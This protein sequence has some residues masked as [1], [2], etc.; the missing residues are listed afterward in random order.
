LYRPRAF[1]LFLPPLTR[2]TPTTVRPVP[3]GPVPHSIPPHDDTLGDFFARPPSGDGPFVSRERSAFVKGLR[4]AARLF[5]RLEA[6]GPLCPEGEALRRHLGALAGEIG[7]PWEGALPAV[8]EPCG[9]GHRIARRG[10]VG[11]AFI[12]AADD[13]IRKNGAS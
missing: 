1:P 5:R 9:D 7:V 3:P 11:R 2:P 10:A 6:D 4:L 13:F 8:P 12:V